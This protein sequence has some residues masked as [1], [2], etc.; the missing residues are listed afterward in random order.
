LIEWQDS[1]IDGS[2]AVNLEN[3]S[4]DS[5]LPQDEVL[6]EKLAR[7][8]RDVD[9]LKGLLTLSEKVARRDRKLIKSK[10]QLKETVAH[11]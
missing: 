9:I 8:M 2:S 5:L 10:Q 7:A 3:K 1:P 6:R 11:A 4:A